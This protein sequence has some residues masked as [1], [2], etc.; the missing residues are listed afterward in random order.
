MDKTCSECGCEIL[1]ESETCENCGCPLQDLVICPDCSREN[2]KEDEI[3]KNCGCP[4]KNEKIKIV[5]NLRILAIALVAI[6]VITGII[7]AVFS[8]LEKDFSV[9]EKDKEEF[10]E[11]LISGSMWVD[12]ETDARISFRE[13]GKFGII[14]FEA[15]G[16]ENFE[17]E[18]SLK[19]AKYE[20]VSKNKIKV[21][22]EIVKV[23]IE[24]D[25]KLTF[26]PSI[27]SVVEKALEEAEGKE[28]N[29]GIDLLS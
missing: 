28:T 29:N 10:R 3:C 26:E 2:F 24:T 7:I 21:G 19:V 25:G 12:S 13:D 11:K 6:L 22:K 1:S 17:M 23:T 14:R 15:S 9:L 18:S 4:L 27:D 20:V 8:A 16:L 5:I